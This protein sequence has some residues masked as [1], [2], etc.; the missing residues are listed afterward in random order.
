MLETRIT[1]FPS[2]LTVATAE[3]P[4]RTS[5]SLGFWV[6]VGGRCEPAGLNGASHFIEHMLFKGTRKRSAGEISRAVEGVG[7]YLNA[8]TGEETTCFYAKARQDR[9]EVLLDVLTDMVLNSTFAPRELD[10]ERGVIKE[11]IAMYRDQ[12]HQRVLELLNRTLWPNH[13]LGRP[14]TGSERTIDGMTRSDL[15]GFLRRNYVT[16]ALVIAAAGNLS[17]RRVVEAVSRHTRRFPQGPRP[18]FKPARGGGNEPRL[19]AIRKKAEQTHLALG[20]RTGSRHDPR[21]YALRLLN[22]ILGENMS[23]RLFQAVREDRGLAYNI[24]SS[25]SF[26]DDTGVL[27]VCAGLDTANVRKTLEVIGREIRRLNTVSVTG[28]ELRRARD[29]VL[30]QLDLS[31]E[32]TENQMMW[33]GE[34]LLNHGR[35][36]PVAE[37]RRRFRSVTAGQIRSV[38]GE[39]FRPEKLNLALISPLVTRSE[40]LD[41]IGLKHN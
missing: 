33:L 22:T 17:H 27:A 2:G 19:G 34:Q 16:G 26:F 6:G 14:L 37:T 20:L 38:A 23:S 41:E 39:L 13:P 7:G 28:A 24:Y 1:R 25:L 36:I 4:H 10:K 21:R 8:F 18:A 11:E 31:L 15:V 29:Y 40:M 5:V 3:M 35:V 30:G 9:F 32:S 12:P